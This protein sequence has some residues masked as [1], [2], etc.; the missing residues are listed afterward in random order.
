MA[1]PAGPS[2]GD[3]RNMT[4]LSDDA[5]RVTDAACDMT[6]APAKRIRY[7][8]TKRYDASAS[9]VAARV[10]FFMNRQP[11]G[12]VVERAVNV[13]KRKSRAL[14]TKASIKRRVAAAR[15]AGLEI[16]AIQPD[17]TILTGK[18]SEPIAPNDSKWSDLRA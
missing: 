17:G 18:P 5:E 4:S 12:T 7:D 9:A 10:R 13:K 11:G 2:K 1:C 8:H 15:E 16:S 6:A 3:L 14:P